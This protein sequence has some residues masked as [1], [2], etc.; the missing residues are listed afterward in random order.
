MENIKAKIK[1][2]TIAVEIEN[3]PY[4]VLFPEDKI[5]LLI[6]MI[7]SLSDKGKLNI[8]EAPEWCKFTSLI[9]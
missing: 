3:K 7:Q 2:L 1:K 9:D 6:I 5:E 8:C 4:F